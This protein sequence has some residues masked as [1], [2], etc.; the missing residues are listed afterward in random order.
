[1]FL[2]Y[3]ELPF[4]HGRPESTGILKLTPEDFIVEEIPLFLPCGEG[5]HLFLW[6]EKRHETTEQVVKSLVDM[7]GLP[8]RAISYAGL[9]DKQ[10]LTRQW[11]SLHAPGQ[12]F[13]D[14]PTWAGE[15]W[16]VL[17][18]GRHQKKLKTGNLRGNHFELNLHEVSN[19][20]EVEQKLQQVQAHG[21]PNYFTAQRFGHQGENLRQATRMLLEGKKVKNRFLS[22]IYLSAIRSYLFNKIVSERLNKGQWNHVIP[23]DVLQLSG[24]KSHFIAEDSF[25]ELERRLRERDIN[26]CAILWGKGKQMAQ[27]DALR[28]QSDSL[29]PFMDYLN[30]LERMKVE[31]A[32]RATVLWPEHLRWSWPE[33]NR[34]H[35]AFSLPAGSYATALVRELIDTI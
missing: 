13:P 5:E 2:D 1:M 3:L 22:G 18:H 34:L 19:P 11:F 27:H 26:P 14:S 20:Q 21:V 28:L 29:E 24:S 9:K 17:S 33:K 4:A 15:N 31:R 12:D 10:A 23:G 6:I 25:S 16:R 8:P 35:L 32:Y 7:S 30:A